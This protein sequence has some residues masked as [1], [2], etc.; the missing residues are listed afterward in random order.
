MLVGLGEGAA[1]HARADD[2]YLGDETVGLEAVGKRVVLVGLWFTE[3]VRQSSPG[4]REQ[5]V[6]HSDQPSK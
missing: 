5:A 2:D 6:A 1:E 3:Y 4:T